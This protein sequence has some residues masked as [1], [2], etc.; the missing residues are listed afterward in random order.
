MADWENP[1]L[2]P[3]PNDGQVFS[4]SAIP[5][6]GE[7]RGEVALISPCFFPGLRLPSLRIGETHRP[8]SGV[9]KM[10]CR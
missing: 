5:N 8:K 6:G 7:G 9:D 2:S 1:A 3:K 10:I 4:L